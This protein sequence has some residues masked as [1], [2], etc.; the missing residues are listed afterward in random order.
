VPLRRTSPRRGHGHELRRER[1]PGCGDQ[2]ISRFR[3]G[4]TRTEDPSL[5]EVAVAV[6]DDWQ[7]R[8]LGTVL[9]H[10]LAARARE[11]G[12]KRFTASVLAENKPM[13]E[14]FHRLGDVVSGRDSGVLEL[15]IKLP[16][17]GPGT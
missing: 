7:G 14:A 12:I 2:R 8:E 15:L 10:D 13:I 4:E 11:E 9:L 6:V 1:E 5:A 3:S 16:A 17:T